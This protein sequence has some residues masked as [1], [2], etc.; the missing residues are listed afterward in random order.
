MGTACTPAGRVSEN[1]ARNTSRA[2]RFA[3]SQWSRPLPRAAPGQ[4]RR[5]G[6]GELRRTCRSTESACR[7]VPADA[8]K[9]L[10]DLRDAAGEP[11]MAGA[12]LLAFPAQRL[13]RFAILAPQLQCL[14]GMGGLD[15]FKRGGEVFYIAPAPP[16]PPWDGQAVSSAT[17][18]PC[19]AASGTGRTTC[20][21]PPSAPGCG[22]RCRAGGSC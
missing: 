12:A 17:T 4:M 22:P 3:I 13:R 11:A 2:N 19:G 15:R 8:A 18:G 21:T 6:Q 14:S 10:G 20:R 5:R 16:H 7:G 9:S 1:C